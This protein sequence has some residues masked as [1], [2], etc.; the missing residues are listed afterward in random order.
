MK[1]TNLALY[2][3]NY[4]MKCQNNME[5]LNIIKAD[6]RALLKIDFEFN[7]IETMPS[8]RLSV[9]ITTKINGK[10]QILTATERSIMDCVTAFENQ[11]EHL[12]NAKI[13]TEYFKIGNK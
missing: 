10:N 7:S 4:I 2:I 13:V 8:G 9:K 6:I 12:R 5:N 11:I 1:S 3:F